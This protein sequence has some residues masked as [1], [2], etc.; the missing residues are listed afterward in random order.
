MPLLKYHCRKDRGGC[1]FLFSDRRPIHARREVVCTSCGTWGRQKHRPSFEHIIEEV[2]SLMRHKI[3]YGDPRTVDCPGCGKPFQSRVAEN[4]D[5]Y[6]GRCKKCDQKDWKRIGKVEYV[7]DADWQD[8]RLGDSHYQPAFGKAVRTK[9]DIREAQLRLR[10]NHFKATD[11]KKSY[12]IPDPETG[13][14]EKQ[15]FDCTGVDTGEI[16]T[17]EGPRK[18]PPDMQKLAIDEFKKAVAEQVKGR[19]R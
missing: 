1:G 16:H 5:G 2:T 18:P 8:G 13:K 15:T 14:M 3:V 10:D 11:G 4:E 7:S 19:G 6:V 9:R 12:M 17:A